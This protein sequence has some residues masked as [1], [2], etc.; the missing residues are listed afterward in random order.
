MACHK[1]GKNKLTA[2]RLNGYPKYDKFLKKVV[3]GQQKLNQ[4]IRKSAKGEPLELGSA[5]LNALEAY[6]KSRK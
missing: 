6:I 5:D 4:M 3:T 1:R 2:A